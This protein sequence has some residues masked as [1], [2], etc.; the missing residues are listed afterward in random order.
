MINIAFL[1]QSWYAG[2]TEVG[3][4]NITNYLKSNYPNEFN[5]HF[6][7][8]Q[9]KKIQKHFNKIGTALY[10]GEKWPNTT[11]YLKSNN[12]HILQWGNISQYA[13]CAFDANVPVIIERISGPRSLGKN[14]TYNTHIISSSDGIVT[15]I[16]NEWNG[17][18][19]VIKNGIATKNIQ[20]N[21]FNF[22]K[23]DFIVVYPAARS[24]IGQNHQML[25]KATIKAHATNPKIKLILMGK[26]ASHAAEPSIEPKLKKL[27]EPLGN[28][29]IFTG[30][31]SDPDPIIS[32]SNLCCV[33][34][35]SHGISNALITAAAYGLP[36]ISTDVGQNNEI[37]QHNKNG[38][39]VRLNDIGGLSQCIL[40]LSNKPNLCKKMGQES[41]NVAQ[42][43]FNIQKQGEK[44]YQLYKS[45][46]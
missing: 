43:N 9:N 39:L 6:I 21:R 36:L 10:M 1:M 46:F 3:M 5:F 33:P 7:A 38:F 30:F 23:N 20:P 35:K 16:K 31:V 22:N 37:C 8:T 40:K 13:R 27:A 34:A 29:C 2:G 12:I 24:G 15:K 4:Y 19:T 14:H 45:F 26:H 44:Y 32:G 11:N 28:S 25:I 42:N 18:I 17:P 41:K